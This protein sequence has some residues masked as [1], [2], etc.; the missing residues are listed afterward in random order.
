MRSILMGTVAVLFSMASAVAPADDWPQ[1][2]GPNRDGKSA[3][4][5]LLKKWP[6]DGPPL[7]WKTNIVGA[8]YSTPSVADGKV[9]VMGNGP[10]K[11]YV[12]CLKEDTGEQL[13]AAYTG[14]IRFD[15]RG[16]PG[17]RSTPTYVNG[18]LYWIGLTGRLV[19]ADAKTGKPIWW[20]ELTRDLG[21]KLPYWGFAESPLVDGDRVICMPGGEKT[22]VALDAASGKEIWA[23]KIGDPA[24]YSSLVKATIGE[25]L[26]Y[27]GF[28]QKGVVGVAAQNGAFI[29]RYDKPSN[30]QVNCSTP[31]VA[32]SNVFAASGYGCGAGCAA[33]ARDSA[34]MFS[35]KE[36]YSTNKFQNLHG[37]YV[38]VDN[39][40]YGC[41]DPGVLVALNFKTGAVVKAIRTGRFSI[42]FADGMLYVR[43]ENGKMD[44]YEASPTALTIRGTF[45]QPDRTKLKAWPHPVIANGKLYLR[46]QHTLLCYNIADQKEKPAAKEGAKPDAKAAAKAEA[47]AEAKPASQ[48]EA[49]PEVKPGPK[50][51]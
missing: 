50:S 2:L 14:S 27:V 32:G 48:T 44:L 7:A 39:L 9:F 41:G 35:A 37:G 18:R 29:W 36:V 51:L 43:N 34:N 24:S 20:R 31:L 49:K 10:T 5:G 15:G 28:T 19:C 16:Y 26:Q 3:E 45:Q 22:I 17:P 47:K 33:I 40:L 1:W 42:S 12:V 8:G 38:L 46:D 21:G 4:T 23:S 30:G 13:W 25:T 11:E 6:K